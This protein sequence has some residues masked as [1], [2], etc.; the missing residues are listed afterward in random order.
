MPRES[1][2]LFVGHLFYFLIFGNKMPLLLKKQNLFV[3]LDKKKYFCGV[4]TR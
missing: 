1:L 3:H 2:C 4:L